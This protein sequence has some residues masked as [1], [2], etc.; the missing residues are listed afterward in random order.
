MSLR[1]F[2]FYISGHISVAV[3]NHMGLLIG[4]YDCAGSVIPEE[5]LDRE[6]KRIT[7]TQINTIWIEVE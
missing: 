2:G 6:V 4:L 7:S 1:E 5:V 3:I